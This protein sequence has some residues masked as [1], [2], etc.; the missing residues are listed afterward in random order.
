MDISG[1]KCKTLCECLEICGAIC[2]WVGKT[3]IINYSSMIYI[4]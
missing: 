2:K 1:I 4:N 3:S